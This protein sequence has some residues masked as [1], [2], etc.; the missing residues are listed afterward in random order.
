MKVKYT[1]EANGPD[2]IRQYGV[3]F[4]RRGKAVDVPADHPM[5][6]KFVNNPHF[7]VV[8]EDAKPLVRPTQI[9]A[10]DFDDLED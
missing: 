3:K 5:A 2:A 9:A 7:E 6:H 8:G 1:G 10:I 4:E